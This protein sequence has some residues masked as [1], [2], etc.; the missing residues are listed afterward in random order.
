MVDA[1]MSRE[2]CACFVPSLIVLVVVVAAATGSSLSL[3]M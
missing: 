3:P 2:I 1:R